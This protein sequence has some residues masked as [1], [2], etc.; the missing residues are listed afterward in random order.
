MK[1]YVG[2][3]G[4]E[5]WVHV[6]E[7]GPHGRVRKPLRHFIHHSPDGFEWGYG[8]SGPADLALALAADII[9]PEEDQVDLYQ[10][11]VGRR[12]EA[13]HQELKNWLVVKFPHEGWTIGAAQLREIVK[14]IEGVGRDHV[15]N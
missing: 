13:V 3:R 2:R 12:A 15:A 6:V 14:E 11:N 1:Q 5:P 4:R 7:D 9:G 10:G 8:G